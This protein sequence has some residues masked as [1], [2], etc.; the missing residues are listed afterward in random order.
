[1]TRGDSS[2][3][4][5]FYLFW[6]PWGCLVLEWFCSI[7]C[8]TIYCS[9]RSFV[10]CCGTIFLKDA[11]CLKVFQGREVM[12][13]IPHLRQCNCHVF[14]FTSNSLSNLVLNY[15]TPS[16]F[17]YFYVVYIK[18]HF[19]KLTMQWHCFLGKFCVVSPQY[20]YATLIFFEEPHCFMPKH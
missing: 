20:A 16:S 13:N 2:F 10:C 18:V 15:W 14:P 6:L 1:M 5:A 12:K 4:S 11:G 9:W 19:S 3:R 17:E 8:D 7:D